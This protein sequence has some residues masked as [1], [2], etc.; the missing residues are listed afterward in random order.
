MDLMDKPQVYQGQHTMSP[1]LINIQTEANMFS[2][3]MQ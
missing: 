2:P 3:T 1:Q